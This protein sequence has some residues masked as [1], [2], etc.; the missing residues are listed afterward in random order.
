ML[1]KSYVGLVL[2]ISTL[3]ILSLFIYTKNTS[4]EVLESPSYK[5][6]E[7][8]IGGGDMIQSNSSN[9]QSSGAV[10]DLV[11]GNTTGDD[12]QTETGSQTTGDPALSFIIEDSSADLG[13]FSASV[14]TM[15]TT[16]FSVINYTSYGYVVKI[17]G[18]PPKNAS[19]EIEA[20]SETAPSQVGIEQFGINLVSNTDPLTIGSNPNNGSFGFGSVALDYGTSNLYRYVSGETIAFAPKSSGK[21]TYTISYLVNVSSLTPGGQYNSGQTIVVIGTY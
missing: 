19:N 14:P 10:G 1:K 16:T 7:I 18:E 5:L 4:A 6:D 21:T 3:S 8:F 12:F 17:I 9:Y 2:F 20:M 11:V 15:T 13:V